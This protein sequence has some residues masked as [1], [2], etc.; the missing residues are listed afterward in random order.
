MTSPTKNTK[1]KKFV[2]CKLEGLPSVL[3][4]W[5]AF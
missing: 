4:V 5:A 1:Q 2:S 3:R